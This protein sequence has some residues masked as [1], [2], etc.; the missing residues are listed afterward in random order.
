MP[1][2]TWIKVAIS[3]GISD[4]RGEIAAAHMTTDEMQAVAD[5]AHRHGVKVTAHS[6]SPA[7]TTPSFTSF[8]P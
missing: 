6:G 4:R 1:R 2:S 8:C 5:I 7:A 3:G